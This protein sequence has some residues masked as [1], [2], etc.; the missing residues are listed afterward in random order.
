MEAL[1]KALNSK[2]IKLDVL[3]RR[4]D[5]K[6]ALGILSTIVSDWCIILIRLIFL[7]DL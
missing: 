5:T 4:P 6:W 3:T 1:Q 2:G 7:A